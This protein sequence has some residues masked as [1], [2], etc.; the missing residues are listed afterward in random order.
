MPEFMQDRLLLDLTAKDHHFPFAGGKRLPPRNMAPKTAE[1]AY[2]GSL[3]LS[4]AGGN[5]KMVATVPLEEYVG[6]WCRPR[7]GRGIG[8]STTSC[9]R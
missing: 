5:L 7:L 2:P 8:W 9:N 4:K 1:R 6:V 3:E